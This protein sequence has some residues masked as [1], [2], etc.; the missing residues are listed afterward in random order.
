MNGAHDVGLLCFSTEVKALINH[1]YNAPFELDGHCTFSNFFFCNTRYDKYDTA[2]PHNSGYFCLPKST[3]ALTDMFCPFTGGSGVIVTL[4]ILNGSPDWPRGI[5]MYTS[6]HNGR[7]TE[8]Y[9]PWFKRVDLL[10]SLQM[11]PRFLFCRAERATHFSSEGS[12]SRFWNFSAEVRTPPR[13]TS[14]H[15]AIIFMLIPCANKY[16]KLVRTKLQSI[17]IWTTII[18]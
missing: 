1:C 6:Q 8:A 14:R 5:K 4:R 13:H 10:Q 15:T 17:H 16:T 3:V 7:S 2:I 18:T 11:S 9:H 12:W